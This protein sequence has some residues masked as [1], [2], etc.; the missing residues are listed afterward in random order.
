MA[1]FNFHDQIYSPNWDTWARPITVTPLVSQPGQPAYGGRAYF[2][3]KSTDVLTEDGGMYSDDKPFID[4]LIAEFPIM[5]MQG[6]QVDIP[7]DQSIAGG[8]FFVQ[9]LSGV[10]NAGGMMNI[11][12]KRNVA[13]KP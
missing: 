11:T 8:S 3:T 10:G 7:P 6:D 1:I 12:L 4:I 5:P 9:D 13:A 2:D